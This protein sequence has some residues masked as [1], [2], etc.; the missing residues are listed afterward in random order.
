MADVYMHV[1]LQFQPSFITLHVLLALRSI[2]NSW[3]IDMDNRWY[4]D[5]WY[6]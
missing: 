4:A 2:H 3:T 5:D 6:L 1:Y